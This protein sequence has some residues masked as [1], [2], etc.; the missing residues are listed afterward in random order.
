[1]LALK[2]VGAINQEQ[3]NKTVNQ[4]CNC[5]FVIR[6]VKE[7]TLQ[8]LKYFKGLLNRRKCLNCQ[9]RETEWVMWLIA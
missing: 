2:H 8:R 5:L 1:M 6:I 7:C 3:Y 4:L 9:N